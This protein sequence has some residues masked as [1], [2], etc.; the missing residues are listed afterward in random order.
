MSK[1]VII[2][3]DIHG[4]LDEFKSLRSDIKPQVLLMLNLKEVLRNG[5]WII[6]KMVTGL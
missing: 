1:R 6:P 3:G 2:Y 5:T 4:C